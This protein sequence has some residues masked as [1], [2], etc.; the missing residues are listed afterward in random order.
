MITCNK[1]LMISF[2][3]FQVAKEEL[4]RECDYLLEAA[5]QKHF[6]ELLSN[7]E[8]YYVPM[9]IDDIS[10]KKVLTTELVT[11]NFLVYCI[12]FSIMQGC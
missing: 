10:S 1:K 11:G 7:S 12:P 3:L 5:N 6:R 2:N 8:G 9:V 4:A